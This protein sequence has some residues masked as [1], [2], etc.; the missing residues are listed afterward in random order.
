MYLVYGNKQIKLVNCNTFFK[1]FMGFMGKKNIDHALMFDRCNSIHTFFMKEKIDV[2]F[3]DRNNKILFFYKNLK[4]NKVILPKK[5]VWKV[6]ETP[7]N[8]F[9]CSL[10]TYL[11]VKDD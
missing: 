8:T 11:V 7:C 3:C 10:N 4:R 6:Y 9:D 2:I 1:R 5:N